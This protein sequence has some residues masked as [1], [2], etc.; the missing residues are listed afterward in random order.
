MN[1]EK[2][3]ANAFTPYTS[4]YIIHLLSIV[5][6][7]KRKERTKIRVNITRRNDKT[8]VISIV[9]FFFIIYKAEGSFKS[10]WF[11]S[12]SLSLKRRKVM[13]AL[14]NKNKLKEVNKH[15]KTALSDDAYYDY[16]AIEHMIDDPWQEM[17]INASCSL[18]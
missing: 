13:K 15:K 4:S 18:Y 17:I 12:N 5:F 7:K 10:R 6:Y 3:N 2:R 8:Y 11:K 16:L 14:I 1:E 9:L